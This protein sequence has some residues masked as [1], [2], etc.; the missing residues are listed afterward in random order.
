MKAEIIHF[1]LQQGLTGG[2]NHQRLKR[3]VFQQ[4]SASWNFT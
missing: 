1:I 4:T 3:A 2:I